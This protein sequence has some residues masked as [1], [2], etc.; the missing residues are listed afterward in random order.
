MVLLQG[1][2][3]LV[4]IVPDNWETPS[5]DLPFQEYIL[6]WDENKILNVPPG[7]ATG[8]QAMEP[9]SKMMIFSDLNVEESRKDDHRFDKSLWYSW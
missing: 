9:M 6:K 8:F 1:S 2:F 3:K 7:F 4:L 5:T